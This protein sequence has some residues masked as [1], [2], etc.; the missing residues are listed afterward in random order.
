MNL[1]VPGII[2]L[3][4][5]AFFWAMWLVRKDPAPPSWLRAM[6]W[7]AVA[8]PVGSFAGVVVGIVRAFWAVSDVSAEHK[9]VVLADGIS[10]AMNSTAAGFV[11]IT[12]VLVVLSV[13]TGRR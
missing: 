5:V 9:Q 2:P 7:V 12:V 10:Q 13:Q 4:V 8:I 11:G 6:P 1:V 3:S